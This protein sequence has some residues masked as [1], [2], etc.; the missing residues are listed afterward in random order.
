MG[1]GTYS[2]GVLQGPL[3]LI[4]T[5]QLETLSK[6]ESGHASPL[7]RSA[8]TP[9]SLTDNQLH[10]P[11]RPPHSPA[12]SCSDFTSFFSHAHSSPLLS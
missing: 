6:G 10:Q 7:L 5:Q 1:H 2:E 4:L 9:I 8:M 3:N 12:R 11:M